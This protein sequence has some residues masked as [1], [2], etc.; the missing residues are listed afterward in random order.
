MA[1]VITQSGTIASVPQGGTYAFDIAPVDG[2]SVMIGRNKIGFGSSGTYAEVGAGT[3]LPV[4]VYGSVAGTVYGL[5]TFQALGTL[6]PLAGSVHVANTISGTVQTHGTSQA[7]G[8]VQPLAGSV[9]V[10]NTISG[11]VQV[12]GTAQA[13]GT[14]QPLAGSVHLASRLPGTVDVGTVAGTVQVLGSVQPVGTVQALGT[15][16][17][18]AGSVH[19]ANTISG[20][21]QTHGTSQIIGTVQPLA[22]S[23]HL[24]NT[25]SGTVQTHG[26]TQTQRAPG[27]LAPTLTRTGIAA[28]SVTQLLGANAARVGFSL[29]A[30]GTAFW[31]QYGTTA[32]SF[33]YSFILPAGGYYEDPYRHV[34]SVSAF[35]TAAGGSV[36]M[37]EF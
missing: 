7:L 14:V 5:G 1:N 29:Y 4:Q 2:T 13:L 35:S 10:A 36:M 12:H 28:N 25:I 17:P 8:T 30:E 22:G 18:L 19:L 11:T 20:T 21:V 37:T 9:H 31:V 32:G 6:Q 16:Q 24:A 3:P 23:V 15:L 27:T 33:S 26:T 34:G